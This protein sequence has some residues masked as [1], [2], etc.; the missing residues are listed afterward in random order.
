[1]G[2]GKKEA[3]RRTRQG[4][5]GDG[6]AN[7]KVKGESFYRDAKR[8]KQLNMFKEG[9]AQRNKDGK[10]IQAASYQ[11]RDVP[12][13]VIEPNRKWFGNTRVISQ[14][15]LKCMYHHVCGA[16]CRGHHA[17]QS[18]QPSEKPWRSVRT[19]HIKFF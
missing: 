11:S 6:M 12:T 14:D 19:T 8:V 10:I 13:A 7:V 4:K 16:L 1:M 9:K 2:T 3:N 5:T 15:S 18:T 17:D